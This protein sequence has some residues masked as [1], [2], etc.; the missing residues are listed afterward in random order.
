[1][2]LGLWTRFLLLALACSCAQGAERVLDFHSEIRIG[3]DGTLSVTEM[4][5]VQAEGKQ[6]RRGLVRDFPADY[7]DRLGN[8]RRVRFEVLSVARNGQPEPYALERLAHG[9]RLRIGAPDVLLPFGLQEYRIAYR[10]ARQIGFF[11]DHDELYWNVNGTGW[12]LPFERMSAE[13]R[14]PGPVPAGDLK[15][16]A[17]TGPQEARGRNYQAFVRHGSAALRITRPL[18]PREGFSIAVAFPK[19]VLTPPS[20]SARF[21]AWL[22]DNPAILWGFAGLLVLAVYLSRRLEPRFS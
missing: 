15:V 20:R 18:G 5:T 12:S 9:R 17:Y 7:R 8:R 14:F 6:I 16:E 3:P 19:G 4:I 10:T 11:E 2:G 22:G 13:V 21:D 1:M